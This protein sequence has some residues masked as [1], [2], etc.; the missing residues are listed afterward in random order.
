ME[1]GECFLALSLIEADSKVQRRKIAATRGDALRPLQ[2][3][4]TVWLAE[5]SE[6]GRALDYMARARG[7]T[8]LGE[9]HF[10]SPTRDLRAF[11]EWPIL[12]ASSALEG[13]CAVYT[14]LGA[15]QELIAIATY[16][17]LAREIQGPVADVMKAIAR[18]ESRH[19]RFYRN[20]AE[21]FLEISPKAQRLTRY[22]IDRYWMPPGRDLLGPGT[23]ERLFSPM[24]ADDEFN[25]A[26]VR[27]DK[28]A[29][30][31]PGMT[32]VSPAQRYLEHFHA[33]RNGRGSS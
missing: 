25:E 19:M 14:T 8:S 26:F 1:Y 27:A 5:E 7:V 20:A 15:M 18:Q 4:I 31:L 16:R 28:V 12:Y 17:F 3:F 10:R 32:G 21:L 13:T 24:L 33:K 2:D 29:A 9:V 30:A 23:F 11:I 6:H 22:M